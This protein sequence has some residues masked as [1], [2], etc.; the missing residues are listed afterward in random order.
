VEADLR[1][2]N[3]MELPEDQ[4]R[5]KA[6]AKR[7]ELNDLMAKFTKENAEAEAA[8]SSSGDGDRK[9]ERPSERRRRLEQKDNQRGGGAHEEGNFSSFSG[10][11]HNSKNGDGRF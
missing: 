8:K 2:A 11:R 7:K 10:G 6:E 5:I 9:F 3:E 1:K 4:F